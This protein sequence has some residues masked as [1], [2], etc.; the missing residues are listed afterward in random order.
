VER[1]VNMA[2]PAMTASGAARRNST[3]IFW[4]LGL[5]LAALFLLGGGAR[6]DVQSLM[7][8]RPIVVLFLAFGLG[9][10]RLSDVRNNR[11]LCLMGLAI[12]ALPALQLVPLPPSVRPHNSARSGA[13]SAWFRKQH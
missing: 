11:F 4:A 9:S 6:G 12:A 2:Q 5:L 3:G 13:R 8:L 7:I 1:D 10:L